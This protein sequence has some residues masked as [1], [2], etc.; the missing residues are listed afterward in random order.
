MIAGWVQKVWQMRGKPGRLFQLIEW[1]ALL[2]LLGFIMLALS[3]PTRDQHFTLFLPSLV[4]NIRSPGFNLGHSISYFLHGDIIN[5]IRAHP[6]GIPVSVVLS[7]R[8]LALLKRQYE[9]IKHRRPKW[10]TEPQIKS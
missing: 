8:A 3:D 1:E 4:L 10:K 6:L 7:V 9:I 5:S 2:W